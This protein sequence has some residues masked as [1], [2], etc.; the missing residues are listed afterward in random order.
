MDSM[1]VLRRLLAEPPLWEMVAPDVHSLLARA[2]PKRPRPSTSGYSK[3]E[4]FRIIAAARTDVEAI[5]ERIDDSERAI[6]SGATDKRIPV[7]RTDCTATDRNNGDSPI[8]F[9]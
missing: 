2:V 7:R 9:P 5:R 6:S 1:S 8:G 4:L 3:A